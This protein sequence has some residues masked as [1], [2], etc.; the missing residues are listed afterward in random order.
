M[1]DAA[2]ERPENAFES[3]L[4]ALAIEAGLTAIE[5]QVLIV[6]PRRKIRVDLADRRRRLVIEGDSYTH[7]GTRT[8]FR[9]HCDRYNDLVAA[10]WTV[11]RFTWEHVMLRPE[12]VRRV[13]AETA[14]RLNAV[15]LS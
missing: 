13:I 4:R 15:D 6:L 12:A 2:D 10:G 1:A 7:H 8:A 5:P 9:A 3:V 14:A 11:L